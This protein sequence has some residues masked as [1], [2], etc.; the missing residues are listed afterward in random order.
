VGIGLLVAGWKLGS[1]VDRLEGGNEFSDPWDQ[2]FFV[3]GWGFLILKLKVPNNNT[4]QYFIY[5]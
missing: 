4:L 2:L 3:L 1:V 5:W